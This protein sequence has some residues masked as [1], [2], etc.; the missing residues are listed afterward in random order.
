LKQSQSQI[1]SCDTIGCNQ[2]KQTNHMLRKVGFLP[3]SETIFVQQL[4]EK[5]TWARCGAKAWLYH[6]NNISKAN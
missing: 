2:I 5:H 1:K 4:L 6:G 3:L